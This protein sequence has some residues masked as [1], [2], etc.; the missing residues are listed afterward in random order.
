[1]KHLL[2]C[3]LILMLTSAAAFADN[4]RM[5]DGTQFPMWEKP[6][7]F[8]K[9]YYVDAT[10]RMPTCSVR[11]LP[12]FKYIDSDFFGHTISGADRMPGPFADLTTMTSIDPR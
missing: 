1:M 12:T 9:T 11:P 5:P 3:S 7:H 6:L 4:S 8:S 2:C 10:R